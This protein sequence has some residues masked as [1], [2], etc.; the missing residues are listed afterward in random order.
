MGHAK[1]A[2]GCPLRALGTS[3]WVGH[4]SCLLHGQ[5]ESPSEETLALLR[6]LPGTL[7]DLDA[8]VNAVGRELGSVIAT[9]GPVDSACIACL[10][11]DEAAIRAMEAQM[12]VLADRANW[13]NWQADWHSAPVI[14]SLR[15]DTRLSQHCEAVVCVP[16]RSASGG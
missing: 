13:P 15:I 7:A 12:A 5:D 1:G 6:H 4:V 11:Y 14:K 2:F 8:L 9:W 3:Q 10:A 16:R